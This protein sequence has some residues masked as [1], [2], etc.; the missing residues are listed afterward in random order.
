[1]TR[2]T[3]SVLVV[4]EVQWGGVSGGDA[5]QCRP[6]ARGC[7]SAWGPHPGPLEALAVTPLTP[8]MARARR[9]EAWPGPSVVFI[10]L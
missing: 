7:E 3:R 1:M 9:G 4:S 2:G 5:E 6:G 10:E 8:T